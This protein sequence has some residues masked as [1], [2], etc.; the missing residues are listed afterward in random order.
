[1]HRQK[2]ALQ[3]IGA[4]AL[5]MTRRAVREYKGPEGGPTHEARVSDRRFIER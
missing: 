3:L 1:M 2:K 5:K 4:S